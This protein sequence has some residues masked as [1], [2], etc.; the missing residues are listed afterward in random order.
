[1]L[2]VFLSCSLKEGLPNTV[3]EA[4]ASGIPCVLS[5]IPAHKEI[6][7]NE[8]SGFIYD[9]YEASAGAK[10]IDRLLSDPEV[11]KS[12][13]DEARKRLQKHF[14]I[15]KRIEK[16]EKAYSSLARGESVRTPVKEETVKEKTIASED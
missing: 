5:D 14:S 13:K 6:V 9:S 16:L 8:K 3:L 2:N 12:V 11:V 1:M 10:I 15:S 7:E 4:M